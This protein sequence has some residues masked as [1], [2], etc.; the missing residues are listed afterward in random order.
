MG[1]RGGKTLDPDVNVDNERESTQVELVKVVIRYIS[2]PSSEDIKRV[3]PKDAG[4]GG[5]SLGNVAAS[6]ED[7][8]DPVVTWRSF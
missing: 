6:F 2:I 8:R 4:V 1:E 5:A 7:F 3:F